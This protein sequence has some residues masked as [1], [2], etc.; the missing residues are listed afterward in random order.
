M[1]EIGEFLLEHQCICSAVICIGF[2][3]VLTGWSAMIENDK[4]KYREIKC[5]R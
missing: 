5:Q 3:V 2:A 1:L 4:Q